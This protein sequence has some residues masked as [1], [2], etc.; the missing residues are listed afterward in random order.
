M[1]GLF[2]SLFFS[3]FPP[4]NGK[5][6]NDRGCCSFFSPFSFFLAADSGLKKALSPFHALIGID[7]ASCGDDL[8]SPLLP[9]LFFSLLSTAR[10]V[11][12]HTLGSAAIE[13]LFRSAADASWRPCAGN[14]IPFPP[15]FPPPLKNLRPASE[16]AVAYI[17]AASNRRGDLNA[18]APFFF[19]PFFF[20][21]RVGAVEA[22]PEAEEV[23]SRDRLSPRLFPPLF[24]F[25]QTNNVAIRQVVRPLR[26][27]SLPSL[28]PFF[29]ICT[30]GF[31]GPALRSL[32]RL[33]PFLARSEGRNRPGYLFPFFFSRARRS[34]PRAYGAGGSFPFFPFFSPESRRGLAIE[35]PPAKCGGLSFS[36]PFLPNN[37]FWIGLG[38]GRPTRNTLPFFFPSP[39]LFSSR[40]VSNPT[41]VQSDLRANGPSIFPFSFPFSFPGPWVDI[42]LRETINAF[43]F[44][45]KART[46]QSRRCF[47][48]LFFP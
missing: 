6:V 1:G 7:A 40:P 26:S 48:P 21:S 19:F 32:T 42:N 38:A 5:K 24:D 22:P 18:P 39:S 33:P 29:L 44:P 46:G 3:P 12:V 37:P 9:P 34:L 13:K 27:S 31:A 25:A 8:R 20:F 30:R 11:R 41:I 36:F 10:E 2:P 14:T 28:P 17:R 15:L 4:S 45:P 16:D 23:W 43:F 47:P 35:R